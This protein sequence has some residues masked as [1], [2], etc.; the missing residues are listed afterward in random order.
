ML[1]SVVARS[2]P[3][4][5]FVEKTEGP[6]G[7][8]LFKRLGRCG[9]EPARRRDSKTV[10][11]SVPGA[12]TMDESTPV[13]FCGR[14]GLVD[15]VGLEVFEMTEG[16]TLS[17]LSA[18]TGEKREGTVPAR[19][20]RPGLYAMVSGDGTRPGNSSWF[21]DSGIFSRR[22]V[23]LPLVGGPPQRCEA[24]PSCACISRALPI[25]QHPNVR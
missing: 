3:D 11:D 15:G 4:D 24:T 18:P 17:P 1:A 8:E 9:I 12:D 2:R 6:K 25:Y 23:E 20:R 19:V 21:G 10:F 13:V 16:W 14:N 5:Q 22:G 7:L